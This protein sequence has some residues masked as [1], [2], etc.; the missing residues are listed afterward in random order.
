[1]NLVG[2]H[3]LAVI[4]NLIVVHFIVL[5]VV[6]LLCYFAVQIN[7]KGESFAVGHRKTSIAKVWVM[8]GDGMVTVNER[9]FADFFPR[10]EDRLFCFALP[11]CVELTCTV[12]AL[13][14]GGLLSHCL[15]SSLLQRASLVSDGVVG[16]CG[17]V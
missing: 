16:V 6:L 4:L 5:L 8:E 2:P 15:L 1:M 14:D 10:L 9:G 17:T 13:S 3:T 12:E 11:L 7:S